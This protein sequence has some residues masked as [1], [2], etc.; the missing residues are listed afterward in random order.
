MNNHTENKTKIVKSFIRNVVAENL[1][2][3][4]Y[5]NIQMHANEFGS[6]IKKCIETVEALKDDLDEISN[7]VFN[8]DARSTFVGGVDVSDKSHLKMISLMAGSKNSGKKYLDSDKYSV[9]L[10][11]LKSK[12]ESLYKLTSDVSMGDTKK[13]PTSK[14]EAAPK[15][16]SKLKNE[17]IQSKIKS[18]K[19]NEY[20][21]F[22]KEFKVHGYMALSNH[23]GIEIELDRRG[24]GLRY[25]FNNGDKVDK[26]V[27][28]EIEY[29]DSPDGR[30]YFEVNGRKYYLDEF[31]SVRYHKNES[32]SKN[33]IKEADDVFGTLGNALNPS[34]TSDKFEYVLWGIPPNKTEEELLVAKVKGNFITDIHDAQKIKHTL[35]NMYHCKNVRIQKID[36]LDNNVGDDFK[37]SVN[38]L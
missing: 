33:S 35:E 37:N 23:G 5:T 1:N 31:M 29:D 24:D 22:E 2:E 10:D 15:K 28:A 6:K 8:P 11:T 4:K 25:R 36:K 9:V 16:E 7:T 30:A 27:E 19:L 38:K 32:K 17:A 26:P 18:T 3:K 21:I 34:F 13:V 12:L 14:N 20:G